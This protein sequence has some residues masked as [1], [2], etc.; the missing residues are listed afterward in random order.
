[1]LPTAL[2]WLDNEG[3]KLDGA[4]RSRLLAL[5]RPP[6][7][8]P[9]WLRGLW[10]SL[11]DRFVRLPLIILVDGDCAPISDALIEHDCIFAGALPT[12]GCMCCT[13]PVRALPEVCRAPG[14]TRI[15]LDSAVRALPQCRSAEVESRSK[16]WGVTIAV[17]DTG[18]SRHAPFG[19]RI[20]AF[21]DFVDGRS[22]AY[23]NHG[24]GTRVAG[25]AA[26]TAQGA[27]LAGVKVLNQAG[28]GTTSAL[29]RGIDWVIRTQARY[30]I[31]VMTLPVPGR[32][33]QE[34]PL[35]HALGRASEAGITAFAG[36]DAGRL[37]GLAAL[38]LEARPQLTPEQLQ[39]RLPTVVVQ[40]NH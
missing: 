39:A 5:F 34:G 37:A 33:C 27:L 28:S 24:H 40:E 19:G 20:I 25:C 16:G 1:M 30:R 2:A 11:V 8:L 26:N 21:A 29:L 15:W 13:I 4:I 36:D 35:S 7:W 6:G 17:L 18:I 22:S 10:Q 32:Y 14:V 31:R 23:D 38:L 3:A 12:L 9:S